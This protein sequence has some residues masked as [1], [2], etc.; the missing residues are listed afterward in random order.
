VNPKS[1]NS[2]PALGYVLCN[3]KRIL[4]T[5]ACSLLGAIGLTACDSTAPPSTGASGALGSEAIPEGETLADIVNDALIDVLRDP[6]AFSRARRFGAL[7]P[8]LGPELVPTVVEL[9]ED[10]TLDVGTIEL[11]LLVHYWA[12]HQPEEASNWSVKRSPTDYRSAAV[13]SALMT[14]ANSDP[15]AAVDAAWPWAMKPEFERIVPSALVRGWFAANNPP[16]LVQWISELP[17]GIPRQRVI[18]A[19]VRVLIQTQGTEAATRWAES[20]S[21]EDVPFKLAVFRRVVNALSEFDLEA[22]LRWCDTQCDGPYG[23]N[24]RSLIARSWVLHDGPAALAWL[25]GSPEGREKELAVR[26][27]FVIWAEKDREAALDWMA[28]QTTEE[29]GPWLE[30]IYPVYAKLL[31]GDAPAKAIQWAERI[32]DDRKR[33]VVLI[34]VARVW[35][36]LDEGAAAEW[37]LQSSLSE[38]AREKVRAPIPDGVRERAAEAGTGA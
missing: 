28:E 22:G 31:S 6:D 30:P 23:N 38:E 37:L 34:N 17:I 5:T 8:T 25:S 9:L 1:L 27:T 26:M 14:W 7:L 29:P 3:M 18:A 33:E 2:P 13:F 36:V 15:R 11:D 35:R 21:D 16:E 4:C 24:L 20:L 32:K 19:Y 12:T 10:R